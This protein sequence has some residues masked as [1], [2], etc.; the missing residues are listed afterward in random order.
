VA[1]RKEATSKLEAREVPIGDLIPTPDN[2]RVFDEKAESF[3]D[4]VASVKAQGVRVPV[5]ARPHRTETGKLDLRAGERRWRAAKEAGLK[6]LPTVIREMSDHEALQVTIVENVE[7]EDLTPLEEGRGVERLLKEYD[8]NLK[9]VSD[10]L[11]R[12][13]T[14][15]R[16]RAR[17]T[18]LSKKWIAALADPQSEVFGWSVS[19]LGLIAALPATEQEELLGSRYWLDRDTTVD[20]LKKHLADLHMEL[21][22][23]RWDLDDAELVPKAGACSVCPK[24]SS[25][26]QFLFPGLADPDDTDRCLDRK[27]WDGKAA[28]A[29]RAKIQ[30]SEAQHGKLLRVSENYGAGKGA[31]KPWQW[32]KA[33]KDAP[34]AKHAIIADTDSANAGKVIWV[35]RTSSGPAPETPEQ[36]LKAKRRALR[37]KRDEHVAKLCRSHFVT[38]RGSGAKL[39]SSVE[40]PSDDVLLQLV[41]VNLRAG[42]SSRT[43]LLRRTQKLKP[44]ALRRQV[45]EALAE[46]DIASWRWGYELAQV[47]AGA[48]GIDLKVM[49]AQAREA[50][51]EPP[52]IKKLKAEIAENK[53]AKTKTAKKAKP[54]KTGQRKGTSK[55]SRKK[56]P[57]KLP[58]FGEAK[59]YE[60]AAAID[61]VGFAFLREEAS[62][63]Y[64]VDEAQRGYRT[65]AKRIDGQG[66]PPNDMPLALSQPQERKDQAEKLLAGYANLVGW[67]PC[68]RECGCT[69][70]N[71][72]QCIEK[73]GEPCVWVEQGLCSA[74]ADPASSSATPGE[75]DDDPAVE[76]AG[77]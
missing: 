31:L 43:A 67:E 40:T 5:L 26:Q 70:G 76:A 1:K 18:A 6:T 27:C 12:S 29:L 54:R 28:A 42:Y 30:R 9:A 15:V 52:A 19:H 66:G 3:K 8:G 51:P 50:V 71:C 39:R 20:E 34:G 14:W 77:Q 4:L 11:G 17:L 73:T 63:V 25:Q 22:K 32:E 36:A 45:F 7:R 62:T 44:D 13:V 24:R 64:F 57:S 58:A 61:T 48:L 2:P 49:K 69:E 74:C 16:E 60:E 72:P 59:L 10:D 21:S 55:K 75:T 46:N 23:A 47:Y 56:K 41:N 35:Q 53:G 38:G 65:F 68:C 33:K 37:E